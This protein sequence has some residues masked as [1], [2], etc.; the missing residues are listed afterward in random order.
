MRIPTAHQTRQPLPHRHMKPFLGP[1]VMRSPRCPRR[2]SGAWMSTLPLLCN[3]LLSSGARGWRAGPLRE[4]CYPRPSAW[5]ASNCQ[6]A[7]AS[8]ALFPSTCNAGGSNRSHSCHANSMAMTSYPRTTGAFP[9][10]S[11]APCRTYVGS[12][13]H[14]GTHSP[15]GPVVHVAVRLVYGRYNI[16]VYFRVHSLPIR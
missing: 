7:S 8:D 12:R 13:R 16:H 5:P 2:A 3:F 4:A 15:G 10:N 1:R 9:R 6:G 11:L 14:S